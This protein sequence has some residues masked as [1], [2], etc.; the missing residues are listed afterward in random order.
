MTL[1]IFA[2]QLEV[3]N[4]H[5]KFAETSFL[6]P[7]H[8]G[9]DFQ[10][11]AVQADETGGVVLVVSLGRVGFHRGDVRVVGKHILKSKMVYQ[12]WPDAFCTGGSRPS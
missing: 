5:F 8:L 3:P 11:Q 12:L 6:L 1:K 9:R 4:W 7:M 10:A 2:A